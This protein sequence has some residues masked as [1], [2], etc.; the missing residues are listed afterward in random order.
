MDRKTLEIMA[1][2]VD[3]AREIISQIN[4]LKKFTEDLGLAATNE[5]QFRDVHTNLWA[6]AEYRPLVDKIKQAA[7]EAAN[8]EISRLEQELAE[9]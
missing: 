1:E 3:K 5:I 6:R 9:L 2:R 4:T 7:Y 8:S